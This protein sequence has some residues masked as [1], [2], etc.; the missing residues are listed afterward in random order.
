MPTK[1]LTERPDAKVGS[2]PRLA[3]F[4]LTPKRGIIPLQSADRVGKAVDVA[5]PAWRGRAKLAGL[6][7]EGRPFRGDNG[8]TL[9]HGLDGHA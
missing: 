2:C 4:G 6:L 1:R 8:Q 3:Y 9:H 5:I 7:P